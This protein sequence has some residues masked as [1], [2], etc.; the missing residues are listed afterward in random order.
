[1]AT[2]VADPQR[3][4]LVPLDSLGFFDLVSYSPACGSASG[5]TVVYS[6]VALAFATR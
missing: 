3:M 5:M 6:K 4:K 1:L 2:G